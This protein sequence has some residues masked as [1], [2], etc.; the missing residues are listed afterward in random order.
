MANVEHEIMMIDDDDDDMDTDPSFTQPDPAPSQ[1]TMLGSQGGEM[2]S[3]NRLD[4]SFMFIS[5]W[6]T[7]VYLRLCHIL[8]ACIPD[9]LHTTTPLGET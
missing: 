1:A 6:S 3:A 2:K 7:D 8:N 4:R 5:Q 9:N